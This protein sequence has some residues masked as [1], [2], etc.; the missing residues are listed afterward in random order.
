MEK[1]IDS[2]IRQIKAYFTAYSI[3][4]NVITDYTKAQ[5]SMPSIVITRVS[6]QPVKFITVTIESKTATAAT[7]LRSR[8][9][10]SILF[11]L[12]IFSKSSRERDSLF[13]SLHSAL[14]TIR[15][16]TFID[17]IFFRHIT[18]F[19]TEND[20]DYYRFS[21]DCRFWGFDIFREAHDLVLE[22]ELNS[23]KT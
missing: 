15:N 9:A 2:L 13:S 20:E 11:Q 10:Y 16:A 21:L 19:E 17:P 23:T 18:H 12:D 8:E 4:A 5:Q 1:F 6:G 14:K 7:L 22:T 3:S